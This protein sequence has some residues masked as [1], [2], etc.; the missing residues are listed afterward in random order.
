LDFSEKVRTAQI[1]EQRRALSWAGG[2][3]MDRLTAAA[4][5]FV[6]TC[7]CATTSEAATLRTQ[8]GPYE[9]QI[10]VDGQPARSFSQTGETWVLG[11]LG[12]RYT[13]RVQNR[14][15]RRIEAVV[16]VDGRDVI[17]G[18]PG[19]VQKR[20]YLVPAYGSVDIDG[21]RISQAQAAA[22]RFSAVSN[23]YAARTGS[24]R[25][26]G[27]IGV[28]V[29]EERSPR[30][31]ARVAESPV[32]G[33]QSCCSNMGG[34]LGGMALPSSSAKLAE[35]RP[36]D[37]AQPALPTAPSMPPVAAP[38]GRADSQ[39]SARGEDLRSGV[40]GESLG[41]LGSM[42]A[43][44]EAKSA[45]PRNRPGLGTEYGEAVNSRIVEV[46][47]ERE[48]TRPSRVIGCRYNDRAGLIALDIDVD[49]TREQTA[50]LSADPFPTVDRGFA[51]PPPGWQR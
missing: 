8:A 28:A 18:L 12:A 37:L 19:D 27:V 46:S 17:D 47:F 7:A 23:S 32:P 4:L 14:S 9:L 24:G 31:V 3:T 45:A 49:G 40:A 11:Q 25:E 33:P 39:D 2:N 42:G 36:S 16:S 10:L 44:A 34:G 1:A 48:S 15:G 35:E 26:V 29:F 6:L 20:G 50:R 41:A 30:P 5:A 51:A 13:L 22:F 21:W 43:R 38:A